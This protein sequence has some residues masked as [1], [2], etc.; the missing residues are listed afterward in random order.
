MD[1]CPRLVILSVLPNAPS[2]GSYA[3]NEK[4]LSVLGF[5]SFW[6]RDYCTQPTCTFPYAGGKTIAKGE[7]WGYF[8]PL[9]VAGGQYTTYNATFGTKMIVMTE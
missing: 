2:G 6:I 5:A 8:V 7:V 4:N 9:Q 1:P 3:G